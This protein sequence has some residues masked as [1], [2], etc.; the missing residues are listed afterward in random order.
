MSGPSTLP[1]FDQGY[2]REE[3]DVLTRRLF[4][5]EKQTR[6]I[7]TGPV[8][9]AIRRRDDVAVLEETRRIDD[10]TQTA[11][12][13]TVIAKVAKAY[14]AKTNN[15]HAQ[16]FFRSVGI[17]MGWNVLTTDDPERRRPVRN[18]SSR[19]N[20]PRVVPKSNA[21]PIVADGEFVDGMETYVVKI[22][23]GVTD[24]IQVDIER[25]LK[26]HE[27]REAAAEFLS[28]LW[29]AKGTPTNIAATNSRLG[30]PMIMRVVSHGR[31]ICHDQSA[32]HIT[33]LNRDR[34]TAAGI[35]DCIWETQKD[36]RVREAHRILQGVSFSWQEGIAGV[37]PGEPFN[38]R[39][40]GRAKPTKAGISKLGAFIFLD[41][42][43]RMREN[44]EQ[45]A[46]SS[47]I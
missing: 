28:G 38:C 47:A 3:A 17:F 14:A 44:Q 45:A 9:E 37:R 41:A 6:K 36:N 35:L 15:M 26:R 40:Y 4:S 8:V 39:C 32:K 43:R 22:R 24:G 18:A 25:A 10:I 12:A 31:F 29:L 33:A 42:V 27:T 11:L 5:F 16:A 30:E 23:N 1:G 21:A 34:Q 2:P 13:A 7:L 20:A 46:E 19:K